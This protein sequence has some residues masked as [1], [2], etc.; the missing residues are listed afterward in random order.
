[1]ALSKPIQLGLA[2]AFLTIVGAA[3]W[4]YG[5]ASAPAP[6]PGSTTPLPAAVPAPPAPSTPTEGKARA[7]SPGGTG[8]VTGRLVRGAATH[9]VSGEVAVSFTGVAP[10]VIRTA[11]R[12]YF[13]VEG[14]RVESPFTLTASSIGLLSAR[15]RD[16]RI[17]WSGILDLGDL[18]LGTGATLEVIVTRGAVQPAVGIVAT[19]HR[20]FPDRD[21]DQE[22]VD[23]PGAEQPAAPMGTSTT[24]AA[25][26]ALFRETPP[27]VWIVRVECPG[28]A[29]AEAGTSFRD[30]ES[31]EPMRI[32]L[33]PAHSLTGTVREA[34]GLPAPGVDVLARTTGW[35]LPGSFRE[36]RGVSGP[37]GRYRIEGLTES[38]ID[39]LVRPPSGCIRRVTK[40]MIP[41][42][43][44]LDIALEKGEMQGEGITL[45][46]RIVEGSGGAAVAGARIHAEV[47]QRGWGDGPASAPAVSGPGGEFE[48]RGFPCGARASARVRA[49]GY[50]PAE[51]DGLEAF[52]S[53]GPGKVLDREVR[54]HRG[55]TVR[56]TVKDI[57]GTPLP[58]VDVR[59]RASRDS[60][61]DILRLLEGTSVTRTREDG[62]YLLGPCFPGKGTM[63][64]TSPGYLLA[65]GP[66]DT[67]GAGEEEPV[68][69]SR[70]VE[71]VE[72][73]EV[74]RD[75]VLSAAGV[76]EG[77]V[78]NA[79]GEP[80]VGFTVWIKKKDTYDMEAEGPATDGEGKFRVEG[81]GPGKSLVVSV[82]GPR[83]EGESA[84][85]DID[86]GATVRDVDVTVGATNAITG[87]VRTRDGSPLVD[88]RLHLVMG[89]LDHTTMPWQMLT[90]TWIGS[91]CIPE[92]DGSFTFEDVYPSEHGIVAF[93]RGCSPTVVPSVTVEKTG[94]VSGIEIVL[95]PGRSLGGTVVD[96]AGEPVAGAEVFLDAHPRSFKT[97]DDLR[98]VTGADGRFA[99]TDLAEGPVELIVRSAGRP[100]VRMAVETG[101]TDVV[102]TLEEGRR[103]AGIVVDAATGKGVSGVEILVKEPG[104]RREAILD[105]LEGKRPHS[106]TSDGEGRFSVVNLASG[107]YTVSIGK[108]GDREASA[109]AYTPLEVKGVKAGTE[110]LRL[111]LETGLSISGSL[112]DTDGK[113]ILESL[114]IEVVPIDEDGRFARKRSTE[115]SSETDGTFRIPGLPAGT[116]EL[117]FN[118]GRGSLASRHETPSPFA[119][120]VVPEVPAGTDGLVVR[121][122]RGLPISG[123]VMD[124]DGNP[125]VEFGMLRIYPSRQEEGEAFVRLYATVDKD[126]GFIT[127]AL[128]PGR[129]Y[130]IHAD[131]F[132]GLT[133]GAARGLEPGAKGVVLRLTKGSAISGRLLLTD[134]R[135]APEG[136]HVEAKASGGG[137]SRGDR[138]R[139]KTAKDGG[140][141][142]TGLEGSEY[143]IVGGGDGSDFAPTRA[144]GTFKPGDAGVEI[145]LEPGFTVSGVLVDADGKPVKAR[146]LTARQDEPFDN[147]CWGESYGDGTFLVK[148]LARGRVQLGV[149]F[150]EGHVEL[151]EFDVPAKDLRITVKPE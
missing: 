90:A 57:E 99:L 148:G 107:T 119:E 49:V 110:D 53:L 98:Q 97:D 9:P 139:S 115:S 118:A 142:I 131:G 83:E 150:G 3:A 71:V 94:I 114:P 146:S 102:L 95:G 116:Y 58:G 19:L 18:E 123:K 20:R 5:S 62:T 134:G 130:D 6:G 113:P 22:E 111:Q 29:A 93:A 87:T 138:S 26:R 44:V 112:V 16:L 77:T 43:A 34:G 84:A 74:T 151:G 38:S 2:A 55:G 133:D 80:R 39:I 122:A 1:M 68:A 63:S 85:F 14:L 4:F 72:G 65:D 64:I 126:G 13:R 106:A 41:D 15:I 82:R 124:E 81:V 105:F 143:V 132:E 30:G 45:K 149:F 127:P 54:L 50:L 8:L 103:I 141:R 37:D 12:G 11:G 40:V 21:D 66:G 145:L 101:T 7:P 108:S 70:T 144:S 31:L 51:I 27:G 35:H 91:V 86:R 117:T 69:P 79:K 59:L 128:A 42:L 10:V 78:R 52:E 121:I 125:P 89:N 60:M 73:V 104:A 47:F 23:G 61:D 109:P 96:E 24:D 33:M 28:F 140:F 46:G 135:P 136:I 48:V 137:S 32:H 25:G 88:P 67:A 147:H 76:V 120:T 100:E 17:P 129:T 92:P 56:G 36:L 75:F